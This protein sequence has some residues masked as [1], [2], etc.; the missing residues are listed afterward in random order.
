MAADIE[1][2]PTFFENRP[3]LVNLTEGRYQVY[4]GDLRAHAAHDVLGWP[5][6]PC[7]VERDV[8][9]DVMRRRAI[10]DNL[11]RE[12]WAP[13]ILTSSWASDDLAGWGLTPDKWGAEQPDTPAGGYTAS[14]DDY[15]PPAEILT[16]IVPGDLFEIGPHRLLC[17]DSTSADDVAKVMGGEKADLEILDPLFDMD[18]KEIATTLPGVICVFTRGGK[19]FRF[20]ADLCDAGYGYHNLVNLTPANG[21]AEETLPANTHEIIHI[22]RKT[23]FFS[24]AHALQFCKTEGDIRATSVMNF[25]RPTTGENYFKYAK[26]IGE[27]S[28][29]FAYSKENG[30]ILDPFLGSGTTMVAAHQLHRRC[31]GIEIDPKYCQ[32]ILDWMHKLDPTLTIT[33]NGKKYAAL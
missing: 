7:I 2:D 29:L 18:Y 23:K 3:V 5:D 32:V 4:A 19:A 10:I 13:D 33:R 6:I 11:H 16:D 27:I 25:G 22:L 8:P 12:T 31:F 30:L 21:V 14:E 17:G 26:P 24:H 20:L 28:Y 9:P 15:E 1:A